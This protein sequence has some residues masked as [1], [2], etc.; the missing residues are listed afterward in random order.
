MPIYLDPKGKFDLTLASDKDKT[1]APS[2]RFRYLNG[3]KWRKLAEIQDEIAKGA[4]TGASGAVTLDRIYEALR[5]G[6]VGWANVTTDD[7]EVLGE[8]N[9][10]PAMQGEPMELP[11]KPELLDVIVGPGE[12]NELLEGLVATIRPGADDVKN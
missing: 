12:A 1:P 8:F 7:A 11:Y 2:F 5:V 6:L 10:T 9:I 4:A 3:R